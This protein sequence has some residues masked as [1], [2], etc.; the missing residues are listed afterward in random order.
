MDTKRKDGIKEVKKKLSLIADSDTIPLSVKIE[1]LQD[2][3]QIRAFMF[4]YFGGAPSDELADEQSSP[5]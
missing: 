1:R 5:L 4:A 2:T 3:E